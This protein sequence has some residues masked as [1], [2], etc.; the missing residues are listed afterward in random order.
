MKKEFGDIIGRVLDPGAETTEKDIELIRKAFDSKI[1]TDTETEKKYIGFLKDRQIEFEIETERLRKM[2]AEELE[3]LKKLDSERNESRSERNSSCPDDTYRVEL[4]IDGDPTLTSL[5]KMWGL[6]KEL[7]VRI[8][9]KTDFA[10]LIVPDPSTSNPGAVRVVEKEDWFDVRTKLGNLLSNG[11]PT[12]RLVGAGP[13]VMRVN[14]RWGETPPSELT[15]ESSGIVTRSTSNFFLIRLRVD[16]LVLHVKAHIEG[17]EVPSEKTRPVLIPQV[18]SVVNGMDVI[19]PLDWYRAGDPVPSYA[20]TSHDRFSLSDANLGI[21]PPLAG[22]KD[23]FLDLFERKGIEWDILFKEKRFGDIEE[24]MDITGLVPPLE[25]LREYKTYVLKDPENGKWK[26]FEG[27]DKDWESLFKERKYGDIE[28]VMDITGIV[29]PMNIL[30]KYG[31][32]TVKDMETGK[33]RLYS[34]RSPR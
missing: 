5:Q 28:E 15:N 4:G 10:S 14:Q 16:I 11:H 32:Y 6:D 33:W 23:D 29:P 21:R 34:I 3:I 17:V 31:L 9:N 20:T 1:T 2:D 12:G 25:I 18:P 22:T 8:R 19:S 7:V 27:N 30:E 26:I 13:Y 24:V